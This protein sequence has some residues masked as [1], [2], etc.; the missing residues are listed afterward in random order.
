MSYDSFF[1]Y[2][3]WSRLYPTLVIN[4]LYEIVMIFLSRRITEIHSYKLLFLRR[5]IKVFLIFY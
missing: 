1:L 4:K 3:I 2:F 5:P